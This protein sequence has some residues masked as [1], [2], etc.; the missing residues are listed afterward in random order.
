MGVIMTPL[1]LK[2]LQNCNTDIEISS[3]TKSGC[4]L[5]RW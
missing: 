5:Q 3:E 4:L 2:I 1:Y